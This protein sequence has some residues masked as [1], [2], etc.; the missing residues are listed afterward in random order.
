ML[1]CDKI[2]WL[3]VL[4]VLL[5]LLLAGNQAE[6]IVLC[7][8]HG[9][10]LEVETAGHGVCCEHGQGDDESSDHNDGRDHHWQFGVEV[11]CG[12]C[13]DIPLVLGGGI[14]FNFSSYFGQCFMAVGMPT[15]LT[16]DVTVAHRGEF[17]I[18]PDLFARQQLLSLQT[19][20]LLT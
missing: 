9:G 6:A 7:I 10:H 18:L 1:K 19:V 14:V 12:R 17:N 5:C 20:I 8:G 4:S 2:N 11:E 3:G 15:I 13:L 16:K